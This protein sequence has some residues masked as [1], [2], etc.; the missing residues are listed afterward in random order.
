MSSAFVHTP[1]YDSSGTPV[2]V[3]LRKNWDVSEWRGDDLIATQ[4]GSA[5]PVKECA[6]VFRNFRA[7]TGRAGAYF[8]DPIAV[9]QYRAAMLTSIKG[10]VYTHPIVR[11]ND[12]LVPLGTPNWTN[13]Q[14]RIVLQ[15]SARQWVAGG[16][17][18]ADMSDS[19]VITLY[20]SA[21]QQLVYNAGCA[22]TQEEQQR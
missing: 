18:T 20:Y 8:A 9:V 17:N 1:S 5:H 10:D 12:V 21:L 4:D 7:V 3:W 22:S 11:M 6:V 19:H 16:K 14:T 15:Q 2:D 13:P